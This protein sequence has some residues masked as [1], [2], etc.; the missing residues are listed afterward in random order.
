MTPRGRDRNHRSHCPV[1]GPPGR[2]LRRRHPGARPGAGNARHPPL[3]AAARIM[4]G[5]RLTMGAAARGLGHGLRAR[6]GKSLLRRRSARAARP[7]PVGWPRRNSRSAVSA[8][9]PAPVGW[10]WRQWVGGTGASG[11]A[12]APVGWHWRQWVG[13]GGTAAGASV[14]I[15]SEQQVGNDLARGRGSDHGLGSDPS[16]PR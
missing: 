1:A 14:G 6:R 4:S 2:G 3:P 8:Q 5:R 12:L 13:A 15:A 10:H 16:H 11:L 9:Q 7:A